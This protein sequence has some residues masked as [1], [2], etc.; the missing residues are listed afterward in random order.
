MAAKQAAVAALA[1]EPPAPLNRT[2]NART[3][4]AT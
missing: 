4:S 1:T 2:I 3:T